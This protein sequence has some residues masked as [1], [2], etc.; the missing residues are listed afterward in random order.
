MSHSAECSAALEHADW[1]G[2]VSR[3]SWDSSPPVASG[4]VQGLFCH[5]LVISAG[6]F[7]LSQKACGWLAIISFLSHAEHL[8]CGAISISIRLDNG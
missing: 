8:E 4:G 3:E 6:V 1:A 7:L 5:L 2:C